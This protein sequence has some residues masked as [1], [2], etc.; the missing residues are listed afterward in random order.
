VLRDLVV[1]ESVAVLEG[2]AAA[3]GD[4][5][6]RIAFCVVYQV[7]QGRITAMRVYGGIEA[8]AAAHS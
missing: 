2:D 6:Q 4:P 3:L 1:G 7:R 5:L 8:A